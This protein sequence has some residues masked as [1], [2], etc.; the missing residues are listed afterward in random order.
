MP[1]EDRDAASL[2]DMSKALRK[3][4]RY[5]AG[6]TIKKLQGDEVLTD[7][8]I[9][10]FTVLGEAA[11]RISPS[12]RAQHPGI[13]W[14]QIVGLRN[15]IVHQYDRVDLQ[16]LWDAVQSD[17]PTLLRQIE[18]LLPTESDDT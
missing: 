13:P 5:A 8:L 4:L 16:A 3:I 7:A 15:V 2:W 11:G 10:Q 18:T 17:V 9:R 12:L 14:R 1:P 6:K